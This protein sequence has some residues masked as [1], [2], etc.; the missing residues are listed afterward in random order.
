M[1][2]LNATGSALEYSTYLGGSDGD[3]AVRITVDAAGT[4][5]VAGGTA[6]FDFPTSNSLQSVHGGG[7]IDACLGLCAQGPNVCVMPENVWY[8]GVTSAD[9]GAIQEKWIDSMVEGT[10]AD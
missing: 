7:L 3:A 10:K 4:A 1:T 9:L 5:F 6:S 2:K 8:H